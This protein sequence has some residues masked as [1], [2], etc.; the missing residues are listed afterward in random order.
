VTG[1]PFE[2][3]FRRGGKVIPVKTTGRLLLTEVGT[4]LGACL[5]GVGI[6]QVKAAS[7]QDLMTR[8]VCSICFQTGRMRGF[9]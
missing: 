7:V 8:A 4:M 6:A 2:W 9:R 5:A 1:Q 3:E